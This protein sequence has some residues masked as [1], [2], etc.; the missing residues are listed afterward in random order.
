VI[1]KR[2]ADFIFGAIQSG[3]TT[4]VTAAIATG[5]LSHSQATLLL[6]LRAWLTAWLAMLPLVVLLTPIN[7]R[8]V[9]FLCVES[10]MI[11]ALQPPW[12]V[13]GIKQWI[14]SG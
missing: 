7:R 14:P 11:S 8:I 1:H 6:W 9:A 5:Q 10:K 4:A 13:Q 12:N 2:Y 3:V